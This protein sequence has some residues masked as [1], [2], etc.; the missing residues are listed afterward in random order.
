[1]N[2]V[3]ITVGESAAASSGLQADWLENV[4]PFV[5]AMLEH[6][7]ID[8]RELSVLFCADPF[9]ATL[10]KQYR[11]VDGPTDVLSFQ[12]SETAGDIAI[13]L[14]TL[15]SNAREFNVPMDEELKRLLVH[16]VLHLTGYDHGDSLLSPANML[17]LTT[18]ISPQ[19]EMLILQEQVLTELKDWSI[20]KE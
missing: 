15:A 13:S 4:A 14:D 19:H 9:I 20:I 7:G 8:G 18:D 2:V 10:N 6:L 17:T 12:Y 16:G 5:E 1:M 11:G 3:E